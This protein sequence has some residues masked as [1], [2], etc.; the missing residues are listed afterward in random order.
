MNTTQANHNLTGHNYDGIQE[1]DNPMP[2]WWSWIFALTFAFSIVS[3]PS[4][5]LAG[6]QAGPIGAYERDLT[7][8][9]ERQ[10]AQMGDIK[11][12]AASLIKMGQEDKFRNVGRAMF[13]N[14]CAAC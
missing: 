9:Q 7:A 13:A 1:Y 11:A 14:N 10:F 8:D 6:D 3:F 5:T 12:D 2:G 4:P